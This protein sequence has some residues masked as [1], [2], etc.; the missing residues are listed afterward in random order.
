[1]NTRQKPSE[2]RLT[3]RLGVLVL[4]M[5]HMVGATVLPAADGSLDVEGYTTPTHIE[6]EGRDDCAPHHDHVFC[7]AVG[8]TALANP[9]G[10]AAEVAHVFEQA[11]APAVREVEDHR[12]RSDTRSDAS[13]PRAP[14]TA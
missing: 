8:S 7:Q 11:A 14:P 2:L 5:L 1:M 6:S 12:A 13:S 3:R 4:A 10:P 9:S